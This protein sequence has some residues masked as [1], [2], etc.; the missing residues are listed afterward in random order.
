MISASWENKSRVAAG[1]CKKLNSLFLLGIVNED[2][3]ENK[4][5]EEDNSA[6]E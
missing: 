3:Y 1:E 2:D 5:A 6:G 4:P